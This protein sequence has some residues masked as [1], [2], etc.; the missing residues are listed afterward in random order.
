MNMTDE[1]RRL[2]I[3]RIINEKLAA[4]GKDQDPN[5]PDMEEFFNFDDD[6]VDDRD[7]NS[8]GNKKHGKTCSPSAPHPSDDSDEENFSAPEADKNAAERNLVEPE[9]LTNSSRLEP[10][11]VDVH[12]LEALR[13]CV[14]HVDNVDSLIPILN[15][16]LNI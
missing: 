15:G 7:S 2:A 9:T 4:A 3:Y 1:A 13:R 11:G 8:S 14:W 10:E 12:K 5:S 16:I 6:D